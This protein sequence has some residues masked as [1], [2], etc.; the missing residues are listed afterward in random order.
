MSIVILLLKLSG[1]SPETRYKFEPMKEDIELGNSSY[2]MVLVQIPMFNEREV[3]QLSIG[4]ACGLSW[5]SDRLIIQVLDDSTDLTIKDMVELE[6][7]RWA[8][9]GINIKYEV[10]DNRKGY[11]AGA[12]R[13]GMKRGY[14]KSCDFVVIFDADFQPE[15]DFLTRTIPFLVHNP[16]LALVQARWEFVNADECLMTRLQE[17]SLDYHF[18]VEQEVGS[19]TYA[20]FGFNGTAGVWRIAA[21]NEAGGWKDRTTVEDMDLAVRASLK[22]WKFLYL[23]TVKVKN[24]LPSTFKAYRYQQHRWS[25]GPANLFRKMVMEIVRN[26]KVSLWKK[27]HVIYSFFFVRKII[28]HIITF[29]LYCVVLPATVVIPEVQVPKWAAVYIPTVITMLNAVGTPRS[30]HLLVFWILFENVMSL[31]RTMATFIGLLEGVRVNEWIVTEKLGG[32]LKAK[33]AAKAPRIRRIYLLELGV[34]AFLFSCGCYDVLFGNNHYF[35]YLFVQA[36]AFFV[37]GFGYVGLMDSVVLQLCYDG[38]WETL[39]DGRTEYVN[40]KNTAFLVRKDCTFEQFMARVYEVLQIN[41]IEYSLSMKTTLRSSNTMYRACSLPMDIFNDEMVNVVLHMASDVV[42]YGCIPIFVTTHPRVPAENPEPLVESESSFRANESVPDIEEEVLPQQMSFQQHYSPVNENN[43]TIDDNGITI[44][45]V[46]DNVLPLGTLL[47]QH[48]SPFQNNEFR[49]YDDPGY[50]TN[51]T[52]ADNVQGMNSNTEVDDRDTGHSD[53][54]I[55]NEDEHQYDIPVNNRENR[56]IPPMARSRRRTTVDPLVSLAPVLPSNLVAPDL[57]RSCNSADIGVGKL[58]VEKNELILELRKVALRE[59]FDFKI[60]RSTTTRFEAHC[61]S[62]SCN[63]RLRATRGSDEHNVPWV[64]RRVDNVHTCSNEV[65]PSGLRQVRSRVVGH[66]IA[67]K[68]IQDKRIYTP[69]DIRTDMQQEY[70]VQLTYQQAYRA[71]EVGLEI[72]RGNPAESYN[73]LP[74]YSHVLTKANEG[75]VTHLQRD[76]DDNFLYYFVA[77]GSSIKGFTQYIRPVIAVDGTH[78]KGLYRGSMFVATCLDGNNQ[79]Y[80]LAIG[81]MDSENNDAWEWFMTKLHGVIGDRP[82]L[83]FISDRCTAIKRAVLKAFHTASHGVCFYHVKGNI[84]SKFRM[85]K[86]IWDQFEPAFIN[87]AKAYGHEEFKRQLEG[88]WML[89]SAAADYL[90][91]N[92]GTCNWARSEFEGRRY[93]ILTTNI[94]ESVNSLMR[95]P[96]KFPITHLVDHFRKTL[97]QWFYDRKIVAESMST[98]LTTWADEIVGERRILAERMTVRP[99]SQHRFHVLGGGM[100]EGIV[101]IHERTCSCRVFQLDQLVC[102]HAIAACLIV[103]VDYISLCSDYYSKDSLVM[104]YAE[105]VEPVGDMTDWDIPEEIQEIRV[106]PPIEAPPPGRRPELRIPSIGEDVNRRTVRC[107]RCNQPGHNR[108]RC[109]NP[110]VS[111][112]N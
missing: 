9:K 24:E 90:E 53:I 95:E 20:F 4:A 19:S 49:S 42:N 30:I 32:A 85:S 64:V 91:N 22:G 66:L 21:L 79:L 54:P 93:S 72:V 37:M 101:D 103:R 5:P 55:N 39:A 26:K 29:V 104:A 3:Y 82:E 70:E 77:L 56:P 100:K 61:S 28:A 17:M 59:K 10:R 97:Q 68:F 51:N 76:G 41:P 81:V 1:R 88:L 65:L 58:F 47:G 111:N 87:A 99:V 40:A 43:D 98:R 109:K 31:H 108:K 92:V 67:D 36:L 106:N 96:R 75:T 25:C 8:S 6:C 80:P 62:E 57:V 2:P 7:Q 27:V 16:Q 84:K 18:T 48:Y 45:D 11:K 52:E 74:K 35:I 50:N 102:A 112:P 107:G 13:E 14:V 83:V 110:I 71:K 86:A 33:A 89:H 23:G 44:A 34:G 60:A 46:E 15:S 105:P 94:A 69:N 38:W 63:W 73:L 12:L 78:L